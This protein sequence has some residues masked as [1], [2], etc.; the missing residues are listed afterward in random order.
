[1][2]S[3]ALAAVVLLAACSG[4]PAEPEVVPGSAPVQAA[5]PADPRVSELQVL[6]TELLD[7]IEVMN[8]RLQKLEGEAP[9][10]APARPSATPVPA[11]PQAAVAQPGVPQQPEARKSLTAAQIG[12]RYREALSLYGKGQIDNARNAFQE[13]FNS[14][15]AGDLAD[16][17]LYWIGETYF[18][19]A[20]YPEAMSQY[21]RILSEYADQNKAPDAMLKMGMVQAKQGD[22][23]LA[24][25]TFNKVI[26]TY[27]YSTAAASAR[28]ELK[29]IQY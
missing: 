13:I 1:M 3:M 23:V 25:Q 12:D 16:N 22:L 5:P 28:A 15:P 17:A 19:T 21:R 24:R 26:E 8:S 27:P 4:Q 7:R 9:A 6:V 14:D 2:R 20:K 29:R 10:A 11:A 18:V